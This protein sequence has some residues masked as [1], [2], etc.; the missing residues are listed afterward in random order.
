MREKARRALATAQSTPLHVQG[1][2][3]MWGV[4]QEDIDDDLNVF[5]GR[6]KVFRRGKESRCWASGLHDK[7][8][9]SATTRTTYRQ[10][11]PRQN[12]RTST[13][14][15]TSTSSTSSIINNTATRPGNLNTRPSPC[16]P[17]PST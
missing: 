1:D 10:S 3:A 5:A 15:S 14:V 9:T 17:F 13:I 11:T 7:N 12:H 16:P 2:S 6:K 8:N 4:K